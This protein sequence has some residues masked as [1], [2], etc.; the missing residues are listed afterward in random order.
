M[1]QLGNIE[2]PAFVCPTIIHRKG[3]QK[4]LPAMKSDVAFGVKIPIFIPVLDI[5]VTIWLFAF[6]QNYNKITIWLLQTPITAQCETGSTWKVADEEFIILDLSFHVFNVRP[7]F[8]VLMFVYFDG[9]VLFADITFFQN[10]REM[11]SCNHQ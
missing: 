2:S 1:I 9:S 8:Y 6:I 7:N 10:L 4:W 11:A 5:E 3:L